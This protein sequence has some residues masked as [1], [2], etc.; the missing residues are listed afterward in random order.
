[1]LSLRERMELDL[2]ARLMGETLVLH[3]SLDPFFMDYIEL[4]DLNVPLELRR[5]PVD[6]LMPTIEE[7]EVIEEFRARNDARIVNKFFGYPSDCDYDKKIRIDCEDYYF[8]NQYVVSIKED[9]TYLCLH[10]PKTTKETRSNTPYPEEG[11]MPYSSYMEIK[12]SGRYQTCEKNI[13]FV[14]WNEMTLNFDIELYE[15]LL[16]P[17][18]I[19]VGSCRV[20]TYGVLQLTATPPTHYYLNPTIPEFEDAIIEY[21]QS[22]IIRA[23]W[24]TSEAMLASINTEKS[25]YNIT[26]SNCNKKVTVDGSV[27]LC[28]DHGPQQT[29]SYMYLRLLG[30][31]LK[32]L[33]LT[34]KALLIDT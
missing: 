24:F 16:K 17:V 13:E 8:D 23:I 4:N 21:K 20:P 5:D 22:R 26:C 15:S 33:A 10:S 11:N 27:L 29:P 14:P 2:E 25:W 30:A 9:T 3:R 7:G 18:L 32:A 28:R 1:M 19:V 6:D 31:G 34:L 12:Y